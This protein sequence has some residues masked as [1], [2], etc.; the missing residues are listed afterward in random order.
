MPVVLTQCDVGQV[1]RQQLVQLGKADVGQ[2]L[3]GC[4]AGVAR[5]LPDAAGGVEAKGKVKQ[6][7]WGDTNL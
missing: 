2:Q 5:L 7:G 4:I 1:T 3:A 6:E